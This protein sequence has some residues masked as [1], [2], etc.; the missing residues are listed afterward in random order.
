MLTNQ[1]ALVTGA[2][3]GIGRAI[4]VEL[5]RAG[6]QVAIVYER[7]ADA[8]AQTVALIEELGQKAAAYR[9]DVSQ[10]DQ[11]QTTVQ[12]VLNDFG[13]L[14]ILVNN[15]GIVRDGLSLMMRPEQFDEVIRTNLHGAFHMTHHAARHFSRKQRGRIIN[16][17]SVIGIMGNAGQCNYAAAKAGMIGMTKSVARE[18]AGRNVTCNAIA[19]GFIDT[20]MTAALKDDQRGNVLAQIPM[21]RMGKPEDVA[22]MAVFLASPQ[23]AYITGEV[24]KIDGG[25]CM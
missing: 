12:Q 13:D 18:L 16:I 2:G 22:A 7:N 25:L 10:P 15:A 19:P 24:I 5:A 9:C 8:A 6:A 4:A 21:G 17:S 11:V 20:D 3:R 14:H 23:A 1:V